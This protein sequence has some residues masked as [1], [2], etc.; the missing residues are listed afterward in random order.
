MISCQKND[1]T[2]KQFL[3][4]GGITYVGKIN[5]PVIQSGHHRVMI[6]IP[7]VAD[8]NVIEARI[9]W[10]N[11]ADSI[12]VDLTDPVDTTRIII[13]HLADKSYSFIIKTY[14]E[15]GNSSVPVEL[16]ARS[17]GI[18]YQESLL[19]Q[20]RNYS[21]VVSND[22]LMINWGTADIQN[23]AFATEIKYTDAFNATK[24]IRIATDEAI[25][26]ITDLKKGS[27]YEYRTLFLPDSAAIDTFYTEFSLVTDISREVD[28]TD[29]TIMASSYEP[30]AELV[31][32][33]GPS[34]FLIDDDINTFWH[35]QYTGGAQPDYPHWF[36]VDMQKALTL[37]RVE[38]TGRQ[39]NTEGLRDFRIEGS[40]DGVSWSS[41]GSYSLE[42]KNEAQSFLVSGLPE[43]RHIRIVGTKGLYFFA[44]LAEF[45]V[46]G[47]E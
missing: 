33:G 6:S 26:Y 23:G 43:V 5:N 13:D 34:T 36:V 40:I 15:Q 45:S 3:V 28:K 47:Y 46:F 30:T 25:T 32:G 31:R 20:I 12:H 18:S 24:T 4:P 29:W 22:D 41:Y 44:T 7:R 19:P 17:F 9:F 2:F 35:T 27:N 37:T 14:D 8:P 11:F 10:D 38:L 16:I 21:E 1:S 42:Q 39:N